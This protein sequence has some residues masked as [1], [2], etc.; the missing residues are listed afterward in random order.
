MWVLLIRFVLSSPQ[1]HHRGGLR[2]T[3]PR[4]QYYRVGRLRVT[5]GRIPTT[6]RGAPAPP[7]DAHP[8]RS[9]TTS[10]SC[11]AAK[12]RSCVAHAAGYTSCTLWNVPGSWTSRT[13][14][15]LSVSI[16]F[17]SGVVIGPSLG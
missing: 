2:A 11:C 7:L 4:Y 9:L 5:G 1:R 14:F 6:K 10:P 17:C 3:I 12:C 8:H 13:L 15:R 16:C